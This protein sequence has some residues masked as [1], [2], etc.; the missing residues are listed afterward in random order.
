MKRTNSTIISLLE[1][2]VE[3]NRAHIKDLEE[4]IG[5]VKGI[6]KL[7]ALDNRILKANLYELSSLYFKRKNNEG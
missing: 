2:E 1:E 7:L 5:Q 3:R 6:N 4:D